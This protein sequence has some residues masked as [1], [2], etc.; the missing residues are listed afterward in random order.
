M[1]ACHKIF[2]NYDVSTLYAIGSFE[3]L[4]F[5]AEN[6]DNVEAW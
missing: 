2:Q 1:L 4:A 6:H 5:V 3:S